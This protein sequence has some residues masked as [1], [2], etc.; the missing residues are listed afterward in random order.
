L[1]KT[2]IDYKILLIVR[3]ERC[4]SRDIKFGG[5]YLGLIKAVRMA[6]CFFGGAGLS[7]PGLAPAAST[8]YGAPPF[9]DGSSV[10]GWSIRQ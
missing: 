2:I 1:K 6:K 4:M 3:H 8:A 9:D 10:I 7:A 5:Y